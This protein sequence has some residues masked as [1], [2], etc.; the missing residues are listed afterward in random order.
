MF[1]K[2]IKMNKAEKDALVN[3]GNIYF[4]QGKYDIAIADYNECLKIDSNE[5]LALENRGAAYG[6]IGKFDLALADMTQALK[7]KPQSLNG[8]ANRALVEQMLNK[9]QEAIDDLYLHLK[10]T[11][12]ETGG[13]Y[14]A[15]GV[16]QMNLNQFPNAIE[17]FNKALSLNENPQFLYNRAL[18]F[19]KSGNKPNARN[20][21]ERSI[22]LG[23][24]LD[25]AFLNQLK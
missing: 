14:N 6:A 10:Y 25:P 9:H 8:Y 7:L 2:A 4:N 11:P 3:R 22:K 19:L 18:A 1:T 21:V 16:S 17:S 24:K 20:D 13:I 5:Q 12:D 15:I 23:A